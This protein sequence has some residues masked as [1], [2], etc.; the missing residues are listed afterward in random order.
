MWSQPLKNKDD[1][2]YI[3]V[4]LISLFIN[5]S[6]NVKRSISLSP[7]CSPRSVV[8][9]CGAKDLASTRKIQNLVRKT[10]DRLRNHRKSNST[11]AVPIQAL[12]NASK[13]C[14]TLN[15]S[16][17]FDKSGMNDPSVF[18]EYIAALFPCMNVKI[19]TNGKVETKKH[20]IIYL[21][22]G[23]LEK[24][25][26]MDLSDVVELHERKNKIEIVNPPFVVFDLTRLNH[27][28]EY[29]DDVQVFPD[30]RLDLGGSKPLLLT[31]VVVWKDYHYTVYA[32]IGRT[33]YYFDDMEK[34]VEKIG[35]YNKMIQDR[36]EFATMDGKL[37]VYQK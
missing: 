11:R 21:E 37:F 34:N 32:R 17:R 36:S 29:V 26:G 18:I 35:G 5:P 27:K 4:A 8:E 1:S 9:T 28:G 15:D 6:L 30:R 12:R 7:E 16:E 2:C 25:D 22:T 33:W 14:P 3:D 10:A 13:K 24:I 31:A 20:P 23:S 19:E